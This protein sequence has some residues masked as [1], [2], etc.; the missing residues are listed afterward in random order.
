MERDRAP[1]KERGKVNGGGEGGGFG[2]RNC[3][4]SG[5]DKAEKRWDSVL[6]GVVEGEKRNNDGLHHHHTKY[7]H[8][9][10]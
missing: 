2:V 10:L 6:G 7:L 4:Y 8:P 1:N 9:N 3:S 5:G